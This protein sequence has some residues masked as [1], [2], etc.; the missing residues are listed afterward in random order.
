MRFP[1]SKPG[2]PGPFVLYKGEARRLLGYP[3]VLEAAVFAK[4]F[5]YVRAGGVLAEVS[6]VD[7][8]IHVPRGRVE[9][10]GGARVSDATSCHVRRGTGY[11]GMNIK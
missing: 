2:I 5:S 6:D 9:R 4:G 7:F 11:T 8:A 3:Q 10:I 1:Y